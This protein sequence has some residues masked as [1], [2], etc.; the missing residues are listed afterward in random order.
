[1]LDMAWQSEFI[2]VLRQF[3][4]ARIRQTNKIRKKS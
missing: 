3:Y 1:M 2:G 4:E